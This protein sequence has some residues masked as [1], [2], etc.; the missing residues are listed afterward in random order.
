MSTRTFYAN[1][2]VPLPEWFPSGAPLMTVA[3]A[4]P[5]S[6]L[7]FEPMPLIPKLTVSAD[8]LRLIAAGRLGGQAGK[9]TV[10]WMKLW[11]ERISLIGPAA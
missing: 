3:F 6:V 1:P 10:C 7:F 5:L 8:G 9:F 4:A 11:V 2:A